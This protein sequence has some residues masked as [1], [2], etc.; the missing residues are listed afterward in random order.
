MTQKAH[1]GTL[2]F[3]DNCFVGID[4]TYI[5]LQ[6]HTRQQNGELAA[7][8]TSTLFAQWQQMLRNIHRHSHTLS[9]MFMFQRF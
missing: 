2:L 4:N 1:C 8:L 9:H 6:Q 3:L 7:A 5:N